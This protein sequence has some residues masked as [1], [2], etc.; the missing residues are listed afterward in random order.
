ML[1]F[2]AFF[3]DFSESL[4]HHHE[5]CFAGDRL[6]L[7]RGFREQASTEVCEA[8]IME[9]CCG[10]Y[11]RKVCAEGVVDAAEAVAVKCLPLHGIARVAAATIHHERSKRVAAGEVGDRV[12]TLVEVSRAGLDLRDDVLGHQ[13]AHERG[14]DLPGDDCGAFGGGA[15]DLEIELVALGSLGGDGTTRYESDLLIVA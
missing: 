4:E 10:C 5:Y 14:D 1:W 15:A 3:I 8:C 6:F 11:A 7:A 9:E 12:V 13:L 2:L